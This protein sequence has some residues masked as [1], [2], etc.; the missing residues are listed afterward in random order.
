LATTVFKPFLILRDGYNAAKDSLRCFRHLL[1]FGANVKNRD[2]VDRRID[3]FAVIGGCVEIIQILKRDHRRKY[4][5]YSV[6]SADNFGM[7]ASAGFP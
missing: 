6:S 5:Y 1:V 4:I 2:L 7:V 3:E